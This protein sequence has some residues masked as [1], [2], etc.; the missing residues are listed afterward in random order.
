MLINAKQPKTLNWGKEG[1]EKERKTNLPDRHTPEK[2]KVERT[3]SGCITLTFSCSHS[4]F[5]CKYE[6][7]GSVSFPA[8]A[9]Q[10]PS[11]VVL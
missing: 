5:E 9:N 6:H 10:L 11:L 3:V 8:A 1:T 2:C 7:F 4:V